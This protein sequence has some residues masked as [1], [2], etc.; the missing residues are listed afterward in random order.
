MAWEFW[1]D[2][3]G[4]FTDI[5]G[6]SPDGRLVTAKLLSENPERYPDAA[7]QGIRDCLGLQAGE[8]I[9]YAAIDAVKMGTTVATNAL[10]ERKGE[11]ALLLITEGFADLLRIGTQARPQLFELNIHRPDLLYQTVAEVPGR[12]DAE[13]HEVRPLDEDAVSA[14]LSDAR[15]KGISAVAVAL[16][17]GHV[18]P[19]H[20]ARVGRLALEAGFTQVSLSHR[21]SRLAKLVPRGDTT[22]VDA[23]LSPLLRRYVAQVEGA[24]DMGR[25]TGRL[26]FMQSSG[27]LTEAGAF[28]ARMPS[29]PARRAVSSAWRGQPV[30][31]ALTG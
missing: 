6:R 21:V 4:T 17:H 22:V 3:G 1:I 14:A 5:V 9:P 8:A 19:D 24:L 25:A 15:A 28:R 31:R 26:L 18:N 11:P 23:Y 7:V 10:L 2:R 20:E 13:G 16:M 27:G 29:C 30:R 12:L